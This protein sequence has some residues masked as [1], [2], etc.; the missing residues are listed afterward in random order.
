MTSTATT[1][2]TK[3][4]TPSSQPAAADNSDGINRIES[5]KRWSILNVPL[6]RRIQ[7]AAVLLA[8]W[9]STLLAGLAVLVF[10][11]AYGG[12]LR[13]FMLAYV[14]WIIFL[15]KGAW[16]GASVPGGAAMG[17]AVS[18]VIIVSQIFDWVTAHA[19]PPC[20]QLLSFPRSHTRCFMTYSIV[21][22]GRCLR[23]SGGGAVC[24]GG[25]EIGRVLV[26]ESRSKHA[27][28]FVCP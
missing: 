5:R 10:C 25:R 11:V 26:A 1:S 28:V 23:V 4:A 22:N 15:D 24:G 27:V 16:K 7:T 9:P 6:E 18:R 13:Y 2:S 21:A 14:G 3:P 19:A 20:G 8:N 17:T 12:V